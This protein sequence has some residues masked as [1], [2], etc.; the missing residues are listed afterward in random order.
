[1]GLRGRIK[2]TEADSEAV[3]LVMKQSLLTDHTGEGW[4]QSLEKVRMVTK[5]WVGEVKG[6][7]EGAE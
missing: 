4:W 6:V 2:A 5:A 1:M 3:P 7:L